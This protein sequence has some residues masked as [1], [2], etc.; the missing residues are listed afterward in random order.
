MRRIVLIATAAVA[1]LA[2][3][4]VAGA[5]PQQTATPVTAHVTPGTGGPRTTFTLSW[6]NPGQTGTDGSARRTETVEITGTRH[7][8]CVGAGQLSVQPAAV[9]QTMR[10][11]LTPR[12]MSAGG[13]RTWCTGTFHGSVLA[14]EHFACAPPDL[15]P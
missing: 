6:R 9:Q 10:L 11:S 5:I 1:A 8:G 4:P 13:P 3:V 12:R 7:S 2:V 15:C 14:I